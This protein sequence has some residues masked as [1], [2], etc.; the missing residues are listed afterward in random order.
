MLPQMLEYSATGL[1]IVGVVLI[2]Q[3]NIWGQWLMLLAQVLWLA[4]AA[5]NNLWGLVAQSAVLFILTLRAIKI[6]KRDLKRA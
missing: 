4:A 5:Y 3:L 6:W 1:V 2:G